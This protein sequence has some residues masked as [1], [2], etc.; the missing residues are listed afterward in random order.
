MVSK[1]ITEVANENKHDQDHVTRPNAWLS[2]P[3]GSQFM[4]KIIKL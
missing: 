4:F 1:N 3:C 2:E